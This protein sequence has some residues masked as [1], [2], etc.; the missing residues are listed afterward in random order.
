MDDIYDRVDMD[1]ADGRFLCDAL[2][3]TVGAVDQD[4]P[5]APVVGVSLFGVVDHGGDHG[6]GGTLKGAFQVPAPCARAVGAGGAFGRGGR[7]DVRT[8]A[9][10]RVGVVDGEDGR[11][12]KVNG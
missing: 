12:P 10:D 8:G 4:D 7:Q 11:H 3:L 9:W 1:A 2:E 5:A 6:R